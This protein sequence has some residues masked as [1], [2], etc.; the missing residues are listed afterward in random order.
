MALELLEFLDTKILGVTANSCSTHL[1][2]LISRAVS[3][4]T[5]EILYTSTRQ[6]FAAG[7]LVLKKHTYASHLVRQAPFDHQQPSVR[8][9]CANGQAQVS[10]THLT[11]CAHHHTHGNLSIQIL[12][13]QRAA[14]LAS[15][16]PLQAKPKA[17]K[18]K[19]SL[20]L[21]RCLLPLLPINAGRW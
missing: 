5:A 19:S 11:S 16:R 15:M 20:R 18:V 12:K 9:S 6:A 8:S 3:L 14:H 1:S 2:Q 17:E 7:Q 4:M 13:P 10:R 21:L